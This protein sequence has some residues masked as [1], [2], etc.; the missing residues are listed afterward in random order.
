[1]DTNLTIAIVTLALGV[2]GLGHAYRKHRAMLQSSHDLF[3]MDFAQ[4]GSGDG[5]AFDIRQYVAMFIDVGV[6][7]ALLT[8]GV[9][10]LL[11]VINY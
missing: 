10:A 11:G 6:G 8:H 5:P 7:L 4:P 1:M 2:Y 3:A 9:L